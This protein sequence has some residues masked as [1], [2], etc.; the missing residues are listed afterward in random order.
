[1]VG[2]TSVCIAQPAAVVVVVTAAAFA[3]S[4]ADCSEVAYDFE[5]HVAPL[6]R[7][8]LASCEASVACVSVGIAEALMRLEWLS[9]GDCTTVTS[10]IWPPLTV[11]LTWNAP[12]G[13]ETAAPAYVP[14]AYVDDAVVVAVGEAVAVV[15]VD[16]VEA[17]VEAVGIDVVPAEAVLDEVDVVAVGVE[18]VVGIEA[19]DVVAVEAAGLGVVWKPMTRAEPAPVNATAARALT[20]LVRMAWDS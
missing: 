9:C 7:S 17:E 12:H 19:V 4:S 6:I 3:A 18:P 5:V 13:S 10:V 2:A 15:V 16:V 20:V 1:M 11:T 8:T 14:S